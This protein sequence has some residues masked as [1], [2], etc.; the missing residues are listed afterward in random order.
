MKNALN[1]LATKNFIINL[2]AD[3]MV[4]SQTL[5]LWKTIIQ[6]NNNNDLFFVPRI[7]TVDNYTIHDIKKYNWSINQ[8]GWVNWPDYQP[9]IYKNNCGIEWRG[10]VH[11]Q[12]VNHRSSAILPSE[13]NLSI[14]HHKT[15][16]KQRQQNEFYKQI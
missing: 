3:E 8:H 7:N 6:Q 11:E 13:P 1:N 12:L 10:D 14:I 2:D 9:R 4:Y 15:I 16:E 5:Q